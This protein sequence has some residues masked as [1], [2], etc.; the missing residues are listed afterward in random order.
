MKRL[1]FRLIG[2]FLLIIV[3]T[4]GLA[5]YTDIIGQRR[6]RESIAEEQSALAEQII[7]AI[8]EGITTRLDQMRI[9][10]ERPS[11]RSFLSDSMST[12]DRTNAVTASERM[13][14]EWRSA[15]SSD[16]VPPSMNAMMESDLSAELR[17]EFQDYYTRVRG[18][19][20]FYD[21]M[22]AN[23]NGL[24]VA[25]TSKVSKLDMSGES[26]WAEAM[27][28]GYHVGDLEIDETTTILGVPIAARV[29]G[30]D[31]NTLGL[32]HGTVSWVDLI[33]YASSAYTGRETTR[34]KVIR[35]DGRLVYSSRVY[36]VF[37]DVGD[38]ELFL[39]QQ[40]ANGDPL[41][42]GTAVVTEGGKPVMYSF[43][44]AESVGLTEAL[45]VVVF[46]GNE[47][48]TVN[49]SLRA[50]RLQIMAGALVFVVLGIGIALFIS[51][52]IT[53]PVAAVST[54]ARRIAEGDLTTDV[55]VETR[56]EVGALAQAFRQMN[57]ALRGITRMAESVASGDLRVTV[58]PRSERDQ[59]G[60]ALSEMQN[61]LRTQIGQIAAASNVLAASGSQ[62]TAS[63]TQLA[64]SANENA[65]AVTETTATVE[66]VKQTAHLA[67]Q[68]AEEVSQA[69]QR[70]V[71]VSRSGAHSVTRSIEVMQRIQR[72]MSEIGSSIQK[73][74][75]QSQAIGEIIMSVGELSDQ[76][77]LLAVNAAIEA[78]RAGEH[79]KG[80]AVV[81]QEIRTLAEQ[82]KHATEQVRGL[83]GDIQEATNS[84][85]LSMEE[86][87]KAME[88]GLHQTNESGEAIRVLG[89]NIE[90]AAEAA[91]Q[92]AASSRQQLA[93]MDQVASAME[94]IR[95]STEQNVEST[96]LLE[97]EVQSLALVGEN[98]RDTVSYYTVTDKETGA[99][100]Q[101]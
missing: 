66:E 74:S 31:R 42:H 57:E 36:R 70:T 101:V 60:G 29:S 46:V 94:A 93:G 97:Q 47:M 12:A 71:E 55:D 76:S 3:V 69:A 7:R 24:L 18:F 95:E 26:W 99:G 51:R 41:D 34:I 6:L 86:G 90:L 21:A 98:L 10:A 89:Q 44:R 1:A 91:T 68:K 62:I 63:S 87:G 75:E 59:L 28:N 96:R 45:P 56:D 88:E 83:L 15:W 79:G 23:A 30:P 50:L 53:R 72:Q 84:A 52:R 67:N 85:V 73:L 77:N 48:R 35:T 64:A 2:G 49:A 32:V 61:N 27:S 43:V 13:D 22:V 40:D 14:Q 33:R 25:I 5:V 82:S 17:R 11:V 78:A 81:A 20:A 58:E 38:S 16:Q 65:A 39:V 9:F 19:Q 92:I 54:A 8:D 37:E 100:G 4:I 80:F